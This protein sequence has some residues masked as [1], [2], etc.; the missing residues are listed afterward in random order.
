MIEK[1]RNASTGGQTKD[2]RAYAMPLWT[3]VYTVTYRNFVAYYRSPD[4]LVGKFMLHIF[5]GLF[6]TFTFWHL[7][8]SQIDMQSRLFSIFMTLTIS[9]PLIQQ[10]QPRY[11]DLRNIYKS[12]ERNSK[13]YSWFAFTVAA[14]LPELP[15]SFVAG[16][17]YWC[18]W[19]WAIWFPRDTFTSASMW[20]FVTLFEIFYVSFG[21]AIASFAPN[22][23]LASLFVPIFFLFVVSFCGVVVP[24]QALPTFWRTWMYWTTPFKYLL[25]GMLGLV[26]HNVPIM[27]DQSEMAQFRAPPGQTCQSYAG[28]YTQQAGGYVTTLDSGLCGFCQYANGD[29]FA[30]SFNV[31][32]Q[33]KRLS[34][35]WMN[36]WLTCCSTSGETT[37]SSGAS[38]FSISPLYSSARGCTCKV[39]RRSSEL[40]VLR[41]GKRR[42][43]ASNT[44]EKLQATRHRFA[45]QRSSYIL[46]YN[47]T[48]PG[49]PRTIVSYGL[50]NAS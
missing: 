24:Y 13:I 47:L 3:Q 19:Y 4:Y 26:T 6:N 36:V 23:L 43:I 50:T 46:C 38:A 14:I 16:T 8:N 22:E 39:V 12:R 1:R 31:Y 28:P 20:L 18:C 32:Y 45:A 17:I 10:L 29:E 34:I 37:A 7:G 15:W 42:N 40:S 2:D 27:C 25:E 11:L 35:H 48:E 30:A 9:P 33:V 41:R 49:T 44:S 21:Q 5:T